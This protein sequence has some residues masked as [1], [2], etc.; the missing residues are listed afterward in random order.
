M[1]NLQDRVEI[2]SKNA[3]GQVQELQNKIEQMQLDH[4]ETVQDL[5]AKHKENV[6][7]LRDS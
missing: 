7:E 2:L 6:A 5:N 4:A 3:T 1:K